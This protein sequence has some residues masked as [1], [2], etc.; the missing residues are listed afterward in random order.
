M[1]QNNKRC[2]MNCGSL[3]TIPENVICLKCRDCHKTDISSKFYP[4][5][6]CRNT[7]PTTCNGKYVA[8][9]DPPRRTCRH[10]KVRQLMKNPMEFNREGDLRTFVC[11]FFG[12]KKKEISNE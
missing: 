9:D 1:R 11:P 8:T 5:E 3:E 6:K 4:G 12:F 2:C 10:K 7:Y